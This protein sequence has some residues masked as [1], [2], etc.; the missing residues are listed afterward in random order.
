MILMWDKPKKAVSKELWADSYGFEDGPTGGYVP[1]MSEDDANRWKAK[2]TGT[3]LGYPQ[4]EIRKTAGA[5]MT[6]IV[7]L[8]NGYNY[9][10]YRAV[11]P[12]YEGWDIARWRK[13]FSNIEK[14]YTDEDIMQSI[15]PTRGV[16]VHISLNGPAQ[17]TFEEMEE[18]QK[19]IAEARAVLD[20][21]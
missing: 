13:E 12:R 7:S 21:Q 3:K 5:Q 8:G 2:I 14:D 6:I 11:N 1:N 19:A 20:A 10:H 16:N 4:V 15:F 9:K 18:L 17:L